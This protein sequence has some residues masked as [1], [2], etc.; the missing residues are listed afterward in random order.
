MG[1][2]PAANHFLREWATAMRNFEITTMR[3]KQI[4]DAYLARADVHAVQP[5]TL[6]KV[7]LRRHAAQPPDRLTLERW[8]AA[9]SERREAIG[10]QNYYAMLVLVNGISAMVEMTKEDHLDKVSQPRG[11]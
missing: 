8:A 11:A 1:L 5:R 9:D 6:A 10:D 2:T 7:L 3:I 4:R